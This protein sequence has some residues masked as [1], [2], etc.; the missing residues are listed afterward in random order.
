[1]SKSVLVMDTPKNGCMDCDICRSSLFKTVCGITGKDVSGNH[2]RGGFPNDCTLK[3]M[4][5]KPD[6]TPLHE[7]PYVSGWN[8]CIDAMYGKYKDA[9][10]KGGTATLGETEE[11]D[12]V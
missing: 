3:P 6:Y 5:E 2:K 11:Q 9:W 1:M 10:M 4:P 8:D 7:E 12:E